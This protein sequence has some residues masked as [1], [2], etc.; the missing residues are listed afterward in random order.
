MD[1]EDVPELV[2]SSVRL[3]ALRDGDIAHRRSLGRSREIDRG[4]GGD[5]DRDGPMSEQEAADAL[6]RR[7]GRGPHWVIADRHGV[8]IGV[9]RLAPVDV[10]NR[11]AR[12][13]IG[14]LDS[15]RLGQGLG[16]EAIRLVLGYGFGR[17]GLHRVSLTVLADNARAVAAYTRCGFVVE[18]RFRDTLFRDGAWYDD[19][20]MAILEPQWRAQRAP[21]RERRRLIGAQFASAPLD[22]GEESVLDASANDVEFMAASSVAWAD[23]EAAVGGDPDQ[24]RAETERTSPSTPGASTPKPE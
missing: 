9:V 10:A 1:V 22:A 6:R 20:S 3:R 23:A 18:G 14:I 11:S 12:L 17:L 7:F 8:L 19:L 24:A 5:L 2:G 16:T 15:T 4:Y 21:A 13:G